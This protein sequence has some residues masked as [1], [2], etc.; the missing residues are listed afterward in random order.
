[1][2][3][4]ALAVGG[5]DPGGGAGVAADL[6]AFHAAGVFGCAAIAVVTVQSTD[7]MLSSRP[8]ASALVVAQAEEVVRAQRV[9]AIKLGALGSL[10]NVRAVASWL[11]RNGGVPLV[12]DPVMLPTRGTPRLLAA[13][14]TRELATLLLPL[15][16]LVTANAPE[17]AALTGL[18]VDSVDDARRAARRLV[19][20]GA[21]AALVKGGHLGRE[22][23]AVD[24]LALGPRR[25]VELRSRR[26]ALGPTHG[27]GCVL[28]SLIAGLLAAGDGPVT[29]RRLEG[30]V[31]AARRIH[32]RALRRA[33][34]VGGAALVL[35]P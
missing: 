22:V 25:V 13:R 17:A 16:T 14:A 27:T 5:L 18:A 33:V 10:G 24:V 2:L 6:R 21:A 34:D 11:A 32:Q 29:G 31:L 26:L 35:A 20:M 30:A 7:G 3:P 15:S 4:C 23:D 1:V 28:A 8:V 19:A 12:L 9:R